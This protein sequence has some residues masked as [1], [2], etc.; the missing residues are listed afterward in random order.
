MKPFRS[1]KTLHSWDLEVAPKVGILA[2]GRE[3][4][5]PT[6]HSLCCLL[7]TLVDIL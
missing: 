6:G 3:L 7:M 4:D 2:V 5:T 1:G